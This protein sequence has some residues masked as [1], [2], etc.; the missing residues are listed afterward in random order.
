MEMCIWCNSIVEVKCAEDS[1]ENCA[2]FIFAQQVQ[3]KI[4]INNIEKLAHTNKTHLH[5][6]DSELMNTYERQNKALL[7]Y[8]RL[9]L[10][11]SCGFIVTWIGLAVLI[12]R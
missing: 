2:K 9:L 4:R 5:Y 1:Q 10:G 6:I 11:A 8:R 7:Q 3:H 12:I